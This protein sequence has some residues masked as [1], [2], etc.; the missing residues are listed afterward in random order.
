MLDSTTDCS[1]SLAEVLELSGNA[2]RDNQR[3]RII[4]RHM[5][6]AVMSD[7]EL[8][9]VGREREY[10]SVPIEYRFLVD[11]WLYFSSSGCFAHDQSRPSPETDWCESR[12]IIVVNDGSTCTRNEEGRSKEPFSKEHR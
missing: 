10:G 7:E 11:A 2:A 6:L 9:K 8:A 12:P 4:P 5:L 3:S 1:V